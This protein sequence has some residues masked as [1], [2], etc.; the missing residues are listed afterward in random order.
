MPSAGHHQK[1]QSPMIWQ[2]YR[3]WCLHSPSMYLSKTPDYSVSLE[4]SFGFSHNAIL[5]TFCKMSTC[6]KAVLPPLPGQTW[7]PRRRDYNKAS[8]Y[9]LCGMLSPRRFCVS[10]P[11][12]PRSQL[13]R[14]C[15]VSLP[16]STLTISTTTHNVEETWEKEVEFL[17]MLQQCSETCPSL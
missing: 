10:P 1:P 15:F 11:R 8:I 3:R 12:D 7:G 5:L 9:L 2:E 13:W 17:I 4:T 6:V 14:R 16:V